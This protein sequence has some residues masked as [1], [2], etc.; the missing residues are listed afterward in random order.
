[1]AEKFVHPVT[2]PDG[3]V[4]GGLSL[5]EYFAVMAM[6][7]MIASGEEV[8]TTRKIHEHRNQKLAKRAV[9]VAD[10]LISQLG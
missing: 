2:M 7:G 5:R 1:M 4:D 6:Q 3:R 10:A 9:E 8:S